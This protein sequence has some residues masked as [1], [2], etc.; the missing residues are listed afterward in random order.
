MTGLQVAVFVPLSECPP[1]LSSLTQPY[2][3]GAAEKEQVDTTEI[4]THQLGGTLSSQTCCQRLL[5]QPQEWAQTLSP[6][7]AST[8]LARVLLNHHS[9]GSAFDRHQQRSYLPGVLTAGLSLYSIGY[10]K[11]H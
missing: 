11:D 2:T 10:K 3:W 4:F 9:L 1:A 7:Q 5:Q 6:H 8:A